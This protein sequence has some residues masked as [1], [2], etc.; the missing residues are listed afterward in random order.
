MDPETDGEMPP[1]EGDIPQNGHIIDVAISK[2]MKDAY[3]TY[4]LSVIKSRALPD[5][6]DGMKPVHRRILYSMYE[7]GY[8]ADK[9]RVKSA[10]VVG[11]VHK[12][13]HPH[14]DLA[15]YDTMTRL[16]QD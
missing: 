15:I 6:R 8:R 9:R 5:I 12:K 7:E 13:Y 4:A 1:H 11:D 3:I 14:G 2:Q 10:A 16:V